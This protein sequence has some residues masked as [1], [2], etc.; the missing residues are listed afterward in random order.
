M[1]R[2]V[3]RKVIVNAKLPEDRDICVRAQTVVAR[4]ASQLAA[5]DA[6][7]AS[8]RRGARRSRAGRGR[9]FRRTIPVVR[10]VLENALSSLGSLRSE[11]VVVSGVY[12]TRRPTQRNASG[13]L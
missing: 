2:V 1:I 13:R 3:Y 7:L 6:L 8:M 12:D 9:P 5:H 11:Q 10:L 4:L